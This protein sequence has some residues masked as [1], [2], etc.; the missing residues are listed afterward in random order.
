MRALNWVLVPVLALAGCGLVDDLQNLGQGLSFKLP[1]QMYSVSSS[2]PTWQSPPS[3]VPNITCGSAGAMVMDCCMPPPP[4]NT[5][6]DCNVNKLECLEGSCAFKFLFERANK[7]DLASASTGAA[8]TGQAVFSEITLKTL[9]ITLANTF[10]KELPPVDIYLAPGTV[11]M[12]S[13]PMAKKIGTLPATPVAYM[14]KRLITLDLAS[15]KVF[16]DFAKDTKN[17][18]NIIISTTIIMRGGEPVPMGRL[19]LTVTGDVAAKL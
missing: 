9:E 18:F 19:D 12:A 4:Y 10:N 7:I 8:A 6:V 13:S 1:P 5:Q 2:D 15:Q 11:M 3:G 14:G 17:P 16:S